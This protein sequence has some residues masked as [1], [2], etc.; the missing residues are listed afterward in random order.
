MMDPDMLVGVGIRNFQNHAGKKRTKMPRP[1]KKQLSFRQLRA[2]VA[3]M[4]CGSVHEAAQ[5][6]GVNVKTL[7][8]WRRDPQFISVY[9]KKADAIFACCLAE[10]QGA[11]GEA[12]AVLVAV[13]TST[14][15]KPSDRSKAAATIIDFGFR[16][17]EMAELRYELQQFRE[18]K[19]LLKSRGLHN[20]DGSS[21]DAGCQLGAEDQNR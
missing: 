18:L 19:A 2:I 3:L 5:R 11:V 8:R 7:K 15:N 1:Q 6:I 21:D 17:N 14:T 20:I 4:S 16:A 10:M 9:Q 13:M 12:F